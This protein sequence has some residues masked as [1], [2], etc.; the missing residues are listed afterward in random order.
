M[1]PAARVPIIHALK[2]MKVASPLISNDLDSLP[3]FLSA[4]VIRHSLLVIRHLF[5]VR[6]SLRMGH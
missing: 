3:A 1:R 6:W 5:F 4:E 2:V